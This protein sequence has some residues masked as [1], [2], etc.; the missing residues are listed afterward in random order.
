MTKVMRFLRSAYAGYLW[1]Y[2]IAAFAYLTR[3]ASD[4]HWHVHVL[5]GVFLFGAIFSASMAAMRISRGRKS[6][7]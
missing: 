2:L 1:P 5:P 3:E 6:R 4:S 7:D